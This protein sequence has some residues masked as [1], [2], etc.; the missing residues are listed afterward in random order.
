MLKLKSVNI[1]YLLCKCSSS[2]SPTYIDIDPFGYHFVGRK[3][4]AHAIAIR[5]HLDLHD[6]DQDHDDVVRQLVVLLRSLGLAAS[7]KPIHLFQIYKWTTIV[8][9]TSSLTILTAAVVSSNYL[10][11]GCY[12]SR[13][14]VASLGSG[15]GST[16]TL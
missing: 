9:Q 1:Y 6:H 2:R 15:R 12:G 14:A 10:R 3:V 7:L 8:G 4:D 11:R 13:R 16:L 5:L